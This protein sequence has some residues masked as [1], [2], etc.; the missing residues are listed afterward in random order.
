MMRPPAPPSES[1]VVGNS[2]DINGNTRASV[3]RVV[4]ASSNR[5]RQ[6]CLNLPAW[7]QVLAYTPGTQ[8]Q[9]LSGAGIGVQSIIDAGPLGAVDIWGPPGLQADVCFAAFGEI[10]FLNATTS[11]RSQQTLPMFYPGDGRT[12]TYINQPGMVILMPGG[13]EQVVDA[14]EAQ[15]EAPPSPPKKRSN[16][17]FLIKDDAESAIGLVDCRVRARQNIHVRLAPAGE[18]TG[19]VIA[20]RTFKRA[21]ADGQLVQ[22]HA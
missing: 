10:I 22:S 18:R 7:I 6:T 20:G 21:G 14:A 15:T 16:L 4:N 13:P 1:N 9:I 12:C 3:R 2:G 5:A 8:C 17:V 19:L 11:P